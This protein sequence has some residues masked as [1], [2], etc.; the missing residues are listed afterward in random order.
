MA[1]LINLIGK[2]FGKLTVIKRD[3]NKNNG[4]YWVCLCDCGNYTTVRSDSLLQGI[5]KSCGCFQKEQV[6]KSCKKN[7]TKHG[8]SKSRIN[9]I[10]F[11]IKQRCY[12]QNS[13]DYKYYGNKNIKLCSEW[14]NFQNFYNW[15]I[16]NGY[17]KSL[18]IDRIDVNGNY[19]PSNCR[20]VSFKVQENNRS[21]NRLIK[22]NNKI[23][24][25]SEWSKIANIKYSTLKK[26][27]DTGWDI[28]KALNYPV[29]KKL[30]YVP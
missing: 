30:I 15:A 6:K 10:W 21:N 20:W 1:K 11:N 3:T 29:R 8:L 16:A 23:H 7:F 17:N 2:K 9:N 14:H 18:T 12:N 5:T 19:E 24:T 26:R 25:L 4:V 22:H 28:E 13:D 27:I